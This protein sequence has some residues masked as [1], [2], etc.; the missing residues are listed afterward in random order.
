MPPSEDSTN[1]PLDQGSITPTDQT[2]VPEAVSPAEQS[3]APVVDQAPVVPSVDTMTPSPSPSADA[4]VDSTPVEQPTEAE[5]GEADA[6]TPAAVSQ[7][8]KASLQSYSVVNK[9]IKKENI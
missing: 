2:V 6:V 1:Q 7:L 9:K 8:K 4:S 3:A 5:P